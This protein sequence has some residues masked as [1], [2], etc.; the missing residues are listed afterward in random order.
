MKL[1]SFFFW[2][3]IILG[4]FVSGYL[5]YRQ[6]LL[7]SHSAAGAIDLCR[8]ILGT[9]CDETLRGRSSWL[10][11]IPLAGWGIIY[12]ASLSCFAALGSY[13][14]AEF[15]AEA[16]A[17]SILL[18]T[19]GA[20]GSVALAVAIIAGKAPFCPLCL[21]VHAINIALLAV[22]WRRSRLSFAE[23][24][25]AVSAAAAYL[26]K[27]TTASR[28]QARWKSLGFV[29]VALL[30][31]I[32]YQWIFVEVQ[33]SK[34]PSGGFDPD[35]VSAEYLSAPLR[36]IPIGEDDP[37]EGDREAAVKV[38]VFSNF[39]CP[40]CRQLSVGL[41][42][43]VS[44]FDGRIAVIFKHYT[45]AA[46]RGIAA[47]SEAPEPCLAAWS[48][49]AA[50]RQGRFQAYADALF[51]LKGP[52]GQAGYSELARKMG[53]D[54]GRFE[55]DRTSSAVRA[56]VDSDTA[57]GDSLGIDATPAI[58]LNGRRIRDVSLEI[59]EFL[60]ELETV[61]VGLRK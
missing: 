6:F 10:L 50:K 2:L 5:L 35:I 27:G 8:E 19:A 12:Y 29:L 11:G 13:L 28:L 3:L 59:L 39:L 51:A 42:R 9:G 16:G 40:G 23:L 48:A 22:V 30:S 26:L 54:L 55:K 53:L 49:E 41:H 31:G 38:V 4:S 43:M 60:I 47:L 36:E 32:I 25:H 15:R 20:A 46:C 34:G 61:R 52:T 17:G 58:F 1:R 37:V 7:L 24:L 21:V 18:A 45:G 33:L 57:L 56:K 44:Y 14:K